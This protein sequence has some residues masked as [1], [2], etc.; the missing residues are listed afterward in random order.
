MQ[1]RKDFLKE[2][3]L[4]AGALIRKRLQEDMKVKRKNDDRTDLVT[5]VDL[6]V[7]RYLVDKISNKYPKDSFLTEEKTV[8]LVDSDNV[9]IID[10]IDGTMNFIYNLRDFAVSVAFY[11]KGKGE[12]GVVYDVM[13]DEMIIGVKD[14]GVTLND[15]A[16]PMIKPETLKQS[17]VDISLK[18]IRNLK[19][20]NVADFY[21]LPPLVLS[22]RNIGSAA[23][24]IAHIALNRDHV[25]IS[26]HLCI[27][28]IAAAIII[29]EEL[30]GTHNY[31]GKELE[32]NS[33][34]FIF[35][36]ANNQNLYDEI[37]EKFFI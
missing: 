29:L 7:E 32:F 2:I 4:E 15:K 1:E 14:E 21:D 36:G 34:Q 12:L 37:Q 22:H 10:P 6:E 27:W 35:V 30:G 19:R 5:S 31:V 23:I 28:D 3:V 26:D 25:Y 33:D 11:V 24:R 9:W 17:I 8:D 18:T 16:L 13:A 20:Y